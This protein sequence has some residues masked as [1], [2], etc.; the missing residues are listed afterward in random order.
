MSKRISRREFLSKSSRLAAA[1]GLGL[2]VVKSTAVAQAAANEKVGL[3]FIGVGGRGMS[4]LT[5][6]LKLGD[7]E[8]VAISD[9]VKSRLERAIARAGGKAKGYHNYED[10]LADDNVDAV[11]IATP[12]HWHALLFVS[13]CMA[14]KDVYC[15]K[16]MCR[17][18]GEAR[19]MVWAARKYKRVTQI[20][21]QI[22]STANYRRA[23]EIAQ[24][25]CLGKI[26]CVRN[27]FTTNEAPKGV[28]KPADTEPPAD[29]DWDRWLGPAPY[30]PFNPA[31]FRVHRYFKDYVGSWLHEMGP[32]IVDLAFWGTKAGPP[33]SASA[34]GGKFVIDDISD[35]PDTLDVLWEFPDMIMT[36]HHTAGNS[37]NFG[38]GNP[39]NRGRRLS[40]RF[41]GLYGT[42]VADY[43]NLEVIPETPKKPPELPEPFLPESP[44]HQRQFIDCVRSRELPCCNVEYHYPVHIAL[45][46]GHISLWVGRKVRWDDKTG[47]IPD[48]KE[49]NDMVWPKYR[50]PWKLPVTREEVEANWVTPKQA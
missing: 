16:P 45:N 48:D 34:A 25:G 44:G 47:T 39:P 41:Q 35:I 32:H 37:Y 3:G 2:T 8:V 26:S 43:G 19:A 49:A 4:L 1:A 17:L 46:L 29:V 6:F 18:P 31:R 50:E 15:E 33:L 7:I 22:H 12:P 36:W 11:V 5:Q 14:G 28:G 27:F 21:T 30:V 10:L 23:A 9:L 20:G 38:F 40:I 24:S 13:A 42:L